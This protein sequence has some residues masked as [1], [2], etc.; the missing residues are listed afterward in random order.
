MKKKEALAKN[1]PTRSPGDCSQD[2]A[3]A[4]Q[5]GTVLCIPT[6]PVNKAVFTGENHTMIKK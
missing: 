2:R 6:T 5:V 3:S 1:L 4:R